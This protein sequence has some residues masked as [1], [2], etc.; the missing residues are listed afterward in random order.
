[1]PKSANKPNVLD[2]VSTEQL[3]EELQRRIARMDEAKVTLAAL[4]APSTPAVP[5]KNPNVSRAKEAYWRRRRQWLAAN[6][7]KTAGTS[8]ERTGES[9]RLNECAQPARED[10][11]VGQPHPFCN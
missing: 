5:A 11:R 8:P 1:M 10:R 6:P 7:G 3:V 4:T 2:A 9:L